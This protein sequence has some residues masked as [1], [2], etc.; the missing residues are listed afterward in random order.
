M[1]V[2][3]FDDTLEITVR[4]RQVLAGRGVPI[5]CAGSV[6]E[7]IL[8]A[9]PS[10]PDDVL[11]ANLTG[12]TSAWEIAEHLRRLRFPGRVLALVEHPGDERFRQILSLPRTECVV[13]P[14]SEEELDEILRKA[15]PGS[16]GLGR[17][18]RSETEGI[19]AYHGIVGR[20]RAMLDIFARIEK[21]ASGDATV[22]I[23]GESGTGKELIAQAIHAVSPRR[24]RPFV[25]LDCTAIPEGLMESHLF[26]HV[27]GAF[28]GA[29]D[30]REGV[31]ALAHTG[32]LFIDE[33]CELSL[34]LQAK[35]LRVIQSRE[36]VK[37]GGTKPQRT[38]IRLITATNKDP[39]VE[40]ERGRFREDLY[41]RVAVVVIKVPPLR[42]RPEDIP[43]LAEHFIR[44]FA[45]AYHKP[46]RGIEPGAMERM[47]RHP[48]PGNVR[49]LEH[50]LE[51]AVV[52]AEGDT[53]T[54]RDIFREPVGRVEADRVTFELGLPLRE[55]ER[56]YILRTLQA[57]RGNRS[58]AARQLGI[59]VRCLQY[60]LKAYAEGAEAL[61]DAEEY[62]PTL[63]EPRM[64][65]L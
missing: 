4:A 35:L 56:R 32:T 59:S 5:A 50:V 36:F 44:R 10:G 7:L 23:Y 37:V 30:N 47:R 18:A 2:I 43:L 29:V 39:R 24:D 28:T 55:V 42:E 40:V 61:A 45:R 49:Q 12:T 15:L 52:L 19:T 62:P 60:K 65:H 20:S 6:T 41:Y 31:F 38:D 33:L 1:R 51:Q 13:R 14:G 54:E 27:K 21:V 11:V 22:C 17:A 58:E 48:W 25:P 8:V 63:A 53:L 46:I 57:T 16:G 34:P 3:V 26:G 9:L 64:G